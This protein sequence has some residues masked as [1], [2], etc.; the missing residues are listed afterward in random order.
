MVDPRI[1]WQLRNQKMKRLLGY[2]LLLG[3][4]G[5]LLPAAQAVDGPTTSKEGLQELNALIGTWNGVG[6]GGTPERPK[7]EPRFWKETIEW[8]WKFKGGDGWMVLSIKDGKQFKAGELRYVPS[9]KIFQA[10]FKDLKDK[11][12]VFEGTFDKGYLTLEREDPVAKETQQI[13][14]N[15]AGD[16]IRLIYRYATKKTGRTLYTPQF[17]VSAGKEGE[18]LGLKPGEN[19]ERECVVSGGLGTSTVSAMGRTFWVCCSGCR[20]EFL[21]NPEKYIKEFDAKRKAG[22]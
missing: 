15:L 21:A 1:C 9:K 20:D 13:K 7:A 14:M 2:A 11:D 3:L 6:G 12:Q 4:A 22:K 18:S 19:K 17:Y 5:L 16:G 10:T 8:G